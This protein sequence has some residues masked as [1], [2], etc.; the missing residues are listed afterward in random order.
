MEVKTSE[1]LS[2]SPLHQAREAKQQARE[3]KCCPSVA[4]D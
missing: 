4:A 3:A 1:F 2:P